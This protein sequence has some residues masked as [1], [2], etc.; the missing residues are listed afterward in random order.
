MLLKG[1]YATEVHEISMPY[2]SPQSLLL[3]AVL[4]NDMYIVNF[5]HPLHIIKSLMHTTC[6]I[7]MC[8]VLIIDT[9]AIIINMCSSSFLLCWDK[10]HILL[11]R[12]FSGSIELHSSLQ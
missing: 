6:I 3:R 2:F 7:F 9:A 4:L 10:H 11:S 5:I 8:H 12:K 1:M